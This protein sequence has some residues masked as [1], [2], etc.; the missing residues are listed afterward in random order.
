MKYVLTPL[1]IFLIAFNLQAQSYLDYYFKSN[2]INGGIVIYDENKNEWIF[3]TE[4]EPFYN[5]PAAA[6][7]HLWQALVGLEEKVY[8]IDVKDKIKWDGVK[9]Y[10]FDEK[11]SQWNQDTNLIDALK[12]KNDWYFD[13]L[14]TKLSPESY[15]LNIKNASVLKDIK[16]NE[17]SYFW[18]YAASTN[19]NTMILFLKDLYYNNLPFNKKSQQFIYNQL[20]ID[21]KLALHTS[22]TSFDGKKIDWTIGIYLKQAK[23]IYFSLRTYTPL[24]SD[25]LEDYEKRKNLILGEIFNVLGY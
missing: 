11:F 7:F 14:K 12:Y 6:H 4:T 10:F 22:T 1:F 3:N 24:D 20:L 23:P 5:T 19:P 15:N 13:V 9:R 17:L 21:Q 25:K 2:N 16:N 8:K 18:N